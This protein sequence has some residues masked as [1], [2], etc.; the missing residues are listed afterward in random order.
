LDWAEAQV[1]NARIGPNSEAY[2]NRKRRS[3]VMVSP[4]QCE[5]HS[6]VDDAVDFS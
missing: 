4:S 5:F 2:F 1:A 6:A 3:M